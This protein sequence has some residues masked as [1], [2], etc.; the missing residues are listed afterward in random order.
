MATDR[1]RLGTHVKNITP[2]PTPITVLCLSTTASHD[3]AGAERKGT[4]VQTRVLK[5]ATL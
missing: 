5:I 4:S 1:T 3:A 2:R